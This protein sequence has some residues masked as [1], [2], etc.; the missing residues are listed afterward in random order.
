MIVESKCAFDI[1][2][3]PAPFP[4]LCRWDK[5][6]S[7]DG[8]VVCF[9]EHDKAIILASPC[10]SIFKVGEFLKDANIRSPFWTRMAG[11]VTLTFA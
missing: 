10:P 3:L 5:P 6:S 1:A 11:T 4:C 9:V 2:P 8:T 7:L